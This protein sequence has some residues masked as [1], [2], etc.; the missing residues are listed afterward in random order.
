MYRIVIVSS[1]NHQTPS[2]NF[3]DLMYE[4]TDITNFSMSKNVLYQQSKLSN[5]LFANELRDKLKDKSNVKVVVCCPGIVD[6]NIVRNL[7]LP[8]FSDMMKPLFGF[9][10]KSPTQV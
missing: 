1:L 7:D 5:I 2:I 10:F 6:T 9:L 4:K 8:W 3:E